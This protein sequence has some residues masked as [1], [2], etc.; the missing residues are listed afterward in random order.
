MRLRRLKP[1]NNEPEDPLD[2]INR[3]LKRLKPIDNRM[4]AVVVINKTYKLIEQQTT[5]VVESA[6]DQKNK[7]LIISFDRLKKRKKLSPLRKRKRIN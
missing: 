2:E 4:K 3:G 6:Y 1:V 5:K 7:Q